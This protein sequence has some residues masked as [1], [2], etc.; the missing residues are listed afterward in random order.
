MSTAT[1]RPTAAC[2]ADPTA[3]STPTPPRTR[4][5]VLSVMNTQSRAIG[6]CRVSQVA[7]DSASIADQRKRIESYCESQGWKLVHVHEEPDVSGGT[8]LAKR[9]GLRAAVEAVEA[10]KADVLVAAYFD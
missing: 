6:I 1:T 4:A 5:V 3:P 9:A 7:Q 10:G 8:P 2:T